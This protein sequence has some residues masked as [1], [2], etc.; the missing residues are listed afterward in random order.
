MEFSLDDLRRYATYGMEMV[1]ASKVPGG[2]SALISKIL[3]LRK[4]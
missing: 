1:G 2:K 4:R 3:E